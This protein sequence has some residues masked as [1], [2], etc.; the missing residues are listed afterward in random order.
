MSLGAHHKVTAQVLSVL[1]ALSR[2]EWTSQADLITACDLHRATGAAVIDEL[3]AWGWVESR[4]L[5]EVRLLR[6]GP[7]LA[8]L[9]LI[10]VRRQAAELQALTS[11]I[12]H[13]LGLASTAAQAIPPEESP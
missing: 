10:Q 13:T 9:G 2:K 12:T 7:E 11:T 3:V 8:R 4:E 6:L 5:P 1:T